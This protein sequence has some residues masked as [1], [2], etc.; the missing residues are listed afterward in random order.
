MPYN[1]KTI[2]TLP[3]EIQHC[4]LQY[5][6][7]RQRWQVAG[8]CKSWRLM[9]FSLESNRF[10]VPDMLPYKYFIRRGVV[11]Q[12][13][14]RHGGEDEANLKSA[15]HFIQKQELYA[16]TRAY[17]NTRW[18]TA[19]DF[20]KLANVCGQALTEIT[21]VGL[22][23]EDLTTVWPD[24]ILK[25]CPNLTK[26][27]FKGSLLD[28][29][30]V[31]GLTGFQHQALT[32]LLCQLDDI[33]FNPRAFLQT[34][35]KLRRLCLCVE[36][37]TSTDSQVFPEL[38]RTYCP[39]LKTFVLRQR[40]GYEIDSMDISIN[41]ENEEGDAN[42]D[43]FPAV[44]GEKILIS[45]NNNNNDHDNDTTKT[46]ETISSTLIVSKQQQPQKPTKGLQ[47]IVFH[48]NEFHSDVSSNI[49]IPL[50]LEASNNHQLVSL[51]LAGSGSVNDD[52]L[53]R[54]SEVTLPS[55]QYLALKGT[56][57]WDVANVDGLR[58]IFDYHRPSGASLPNLTHIA[59]RHL[60]AV[61]DMVL[62]DM[63]SSCPHLQHVLFDNCQGI[64][65]T[66][67]IQFLTR[68]AR[69]LRTITIEQSG[70]ALTPRVLHVIATTLV[71]LEQLTIE[72]FQYDFLALADVEKFLDA[73]RRQLVEQNKKNHK[74][75]KLYIHF[76]FDSSLDYPSKHDVDRFLQKLDSS[77][78][79]W[80]YSI[81]MPDEEIQLV[82]DCRGDEVDQKITHVEYRRN[83][84]A[85][86]IHSKSCKE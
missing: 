40:P 80:Q 79:E 8:V 21:L 67:M 38:I 19:E 3:S 86:R 85:K 13:F 9:V 72:A 1:V 55:V 2:P 23:Q 61:V 24:I 7:L 47:H 75:E 70:F 58:S 59:F 41:N 62:D 12:L 84:R 28:P 66:G 36:N 76:V 81:A 64:T 63:A 20:I 11:K 71:Y 74:M 46:P 82:R 5:L 34:V 29:G 60:D 4:I 56:S 43:R 6:S 10:I 26:L 27:H 35:P 52:V 68:L 53:A 18:F 25:S 37:L 42:D 39:D 78:K 16:I 77:A 50:I 22:D 83:E 69:H 45:S 33:D 65:T 32:D 48:D 49:L 54:L 14:L 15:I 17:I 44:A 51:D 73:R 31:T 57:P 30:W